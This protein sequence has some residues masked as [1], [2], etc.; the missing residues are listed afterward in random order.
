[1]PAP[2][3]R[4]LARA[5]TSTRLRP[6]E[7]ALDAAAQAAWR[8]PASLAQIGSSTRKTC[9]RVDRRRPGAPR[10]PGA[11]GL[12]ARLSTLAACFRLRPGGAMGVRGRRR[13]TRRRSCCWRPLKRRRRG[14]PCRPRSGRRL[15]A[16]AAGSGGPRSRA[17][18]SRMVCSRAE[19]VIALATGTV[20]EHPP[21]LALAF[22]A[23]IEAAAVI[24]P[25]RGRARR[26]CSSVSRS[27]QSSSRFLRPHFR[28]HSS[29]RLGETSRDVKKLTRDERNYCFASGFRR[30][31]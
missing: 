23:Q 29:V 5:E 28:P 30:F 11:H 1:M 31:H 22:D 3:G 19:A 27:D 21:A 17:S 15:R 16:A 8:S 4:I 26:T 24:V 2:S 6:I 9:A 20:A 18:A 12:R 10:S 7:H 25:A 13:R 14:V